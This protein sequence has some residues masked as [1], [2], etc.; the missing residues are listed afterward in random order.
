MVGNSKIYHIAGLEKHDRSCQ[1]S[2][3]D[4]RLASTA[5]RDLCFATLHIQL[6]L[7]W[8]GYCWELQLSKDRWSVPLAPILISAFLLSGSPLVEAPFVLIP[9]LFDQIAIV[10]MRSTMKVMLLLHAIRTSLQ[11][12][13]HIKIPHCQEVPL[14]TPRLANAEWQ[15]SHSLWGFLVI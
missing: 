12:R 15:S 5:K 4:L 2:S 11:R 9:F 6:E 13:E 14:I 3:K 8:R 7:D 1:V 10:M